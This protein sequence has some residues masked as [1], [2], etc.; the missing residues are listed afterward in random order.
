VANRNKRRQQQ[1]RPQRPV[2]GSPA[3]PGL[4]EAAGIEADDDAPVAPARTGATPSYATG[5]IAPRR[6]AAAAAAGATIDIDARV[7][8]FSSDLRRIVITAGLML[9][10]IVIASFLLH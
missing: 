3:Q 5:V 10:I 2:T 8:Y 9:A 6:A 4:R 1:R 7:P